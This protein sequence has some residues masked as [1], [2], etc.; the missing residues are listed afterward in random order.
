MYLPSD[1]A[2]FRGRLRNLGWGGCY[3]ETVSP[4]VIGARTEVLVQANALWFRAMA[5]VRAIREKS[6][7]GLEFIRLSTGGYRSLAE[8]LVELAQQAAL[9]P[10]TSTADDVISESQA[11]T[12][13]PRYVL[14]PGNGERV[15]LVTTIVPAEDSVPDPAEEA[16]AILESHPQ[17]LERW[18]S[19]SILNLFG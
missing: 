12:Y 9:G 10:C 4:F 5:Q 15:A 18:P 1:G 17:I 13:R 16:T 11:Q 14:A 3:I 6:G 8:V 7:I 19:G 2:L